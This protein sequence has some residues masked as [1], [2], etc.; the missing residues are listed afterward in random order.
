MAKRSKI[1]GGIKVCALPTVK[2]ILAQYDFDQEHGRLLHKPIANP[3][4]RFELRYNR[5]MAGTD[6][7]TLTPQGYRRCGVSPIGPGRAQN[8]AVHRLVWKLI[9]GKDPDGL[10]D[11]INGIRDDNRP[12]NLRDVTPNENALNAVRGRWANETGRRKAQ[13]ERDDLHRQ[14]A[15]EDR[16]RNQLARLRAKYEGVEAT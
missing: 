4:D 13:A 3:K 15:I 7:G 9:T 8:C 6:A 11:H 10:I 2:A 5:D 16:E 14:A 12:E 1:I